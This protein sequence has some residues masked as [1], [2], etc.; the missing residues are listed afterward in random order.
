MTTHRHCVTVTPV[1]EYSPA[2]RMKV[3]AA[4]R[5]NAFDYFGFGTY[6]DIDP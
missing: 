4:N 1:V 5:L 3:N 6:D 2:F